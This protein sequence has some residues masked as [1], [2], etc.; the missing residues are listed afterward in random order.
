MNATSCAFFASRHH[1]TTLPVTS[2]GQ[3]SKRCWSISRRAQVLRPKYEDPGPSS[4]FETPSKSSGTA[5]GMLCPNPKVRTISSAVRTRP[6]G[7]L[8]VYV[9][10]RCSPSHTILL[11]SSKIKR[12]AWCSLIGLQRSTA[13]GLPSGP[14]TM[15]PTSTVPIVFQPASVRIGVERS[16]ILPPPAAP[17]YKTSFASVA[18]NTSCFAVGVYGISIFIFLRLLEIKKLRI[19]VRGSESLASPYPRVWLFS[20][21]KIEVRT[22]RL[23]VRCARCVAQ[24]GEGR[25]AG[26]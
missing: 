23:D 3:T 6:L 11:P 22:V 7:S 20:F 19:A 16:S 4:D 13:C 9:N 12:H 26:G 2:G 21:F 15:S 24:G 25:R 8:S 5:T 1:S 10:H 17:P 14:N 18:W